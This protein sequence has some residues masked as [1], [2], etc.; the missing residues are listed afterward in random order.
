M[1]SKSKISLFDNMFTIQ[2]SILYFLS[3]LV[4]LI[5]LEQ[6]FLFLL[7]SVCTAVVTGTTYS[8]FSFYLK[9]RWFESKIPIAYTYIAEWKKV[10][11]EEKIMTFNDNQS[12]HDRKMIAI[13]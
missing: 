5:F 8:K 11:T 6:V 7:Q 4:F 12:Y 9:I 1:N 3:V 2:I 10:I 13:A